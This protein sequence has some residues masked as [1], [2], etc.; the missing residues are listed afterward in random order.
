MKN[1]RL[2]ISDHALVRYLERVWGVD[3]E[4]LKRRIGRQLDLDIPKELPTPC[5]VKINGVE[6]RIDGNVVV[7]LQTSPKKRRK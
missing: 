6:Y 2:K 5:G 7:T 4:G 1:P 3:T